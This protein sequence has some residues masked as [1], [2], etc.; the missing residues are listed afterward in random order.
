MKESGRSRFCSLLIMG[1][2]L[3]LT[4]FCTTKEKGEDPVNN[5]PPK[6]VIDVDGNVYQ[7]VTIGTQV[8]LGE[9]LK[10]TRYSNKDIIGTTTPATISLLDLN[11]Y[12]YQWPCDGN[13]SNVATYGRLYTWFAATDS[14]NI[15]PTGWHVPSE[16][17]WSDLMI[18]CVNAAYA[19]GKLKETGTIHWK[20]PNAGA[21]DEFGFKALPAGTRSI[22]GPFSG[23]GSG[24]WWWSSTVAGYLTAYFREMYYDFAD[25]GGDFEYGAL[26]LS[27]RC[28]WDKKAR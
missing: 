5:I 3:I 23:M 4:T 11:T 16:G 18:Y 25:V 7:T 12:K 9:N 14:R 10:T 2:F 1:L 28:I 24:G 17:E 13:E 19:G 8:W 27:V 15:C 21:K 26:G 6:T 22:S 20:N